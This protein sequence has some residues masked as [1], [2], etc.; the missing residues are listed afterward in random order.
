M[1]APFQGE[2]LF[3]GGFV[4]NFPRCFFASFFGEGTKKRMFWYQ[5]FGIVMSCIVV[6]LITIVTIIIN[7]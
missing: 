1:I 4:F 7:K 5:L 2:N 3:F 6:G